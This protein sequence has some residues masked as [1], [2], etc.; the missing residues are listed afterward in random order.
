MGNT[1][2]TLSGTLVVLRTLETLLAKFPILQDITTDFGQQGVLFN[3]P[4]M[5]RVVVPTTA[6]D[7]S[8]VTGYAPTDRT[9]LDVPVT[10]NKH[11][12][13]TFVVDDQARSST[14]RNLIQEW[15]DT[16]A[17]AVGK[18]MVD[19][20][21]ALVLA[22]P[23]P[24]AYPKT[25]INFDRDSVI[26]VKILLNQN[27]VPDNERFICLNSPFHGAMEKDTTIVANLYNK[28]SDTIST[29]RLSDIHGFSP[30]EYSALPDNGQNLAGIAGNK[31]SLLIA[32]RVPEM[33][34]NG[35]PLPGRVEMVTE[36]HSGLTAQLR[37]WYDFLLGKEYWTMTLMYGVAVGFSEA[38][39]VSKR[40]CRI[41]NQ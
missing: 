5:S 31:E 1:Y 20:L 6:G 24:L 9:S 35:V 27:F 2:G 3:Q 34:S 40:L 22:A 4:V 38:G 32:T 29:G 16:A 15:A 11:K 39:S 14:N 30:S 23:F 25:A 28:A 12:F 33:P 36:P 7:W 18:A 26:D 8:P 37:Q 41:V 21:F 13:H 17:Y 19:D 10:I